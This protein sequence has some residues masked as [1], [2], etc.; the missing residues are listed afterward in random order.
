LIR[1]AAALTPEKMAPVAS[2]SSDPMRNVEDFYLAEALE[3]ITAWKQSTAD[4]RR[5]L[6]PHRTHGT[7]SIGGP[8]GQRFESQR[9]IRAF[10]VWTRWYLGKEAPPTHP[11]SFERRTASYADRIR[12][13]S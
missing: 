7:T 2:S 13:I 3:Y 8:A 10:L 9:Q 12:K 6:R 4:N 1:D 11:L 5:H